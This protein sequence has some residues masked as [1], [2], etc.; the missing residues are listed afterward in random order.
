MNPNRNAAVA[1]ALSLTALLA[2]FG[3]VPPMP[4]PQEYHRFADQS[5]HFGIPHFFDSVSNLLFILAGVAGLRFLASGRAR[6]AFTDRREALA[7][8]WFFGASVLVGLGSGYYHLAPD[9]SRLFW[10]RAAIAMA[11][12]SWLA[13]IVGE[14]IDL[15]WGRRLLPL[16]VLAGVGSAVYWLWSE[17]AGRG[18]LRPYLFMQLVP[19]LGVPLL[20]WLY[21]PRY[22]GDRDILVV[23]ALYPAALAC[24]FLDKPIAGLLGFVSG[25]TLKH[26]LAAAAVWWV[27][28]GLRR[29]RPS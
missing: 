22:P 10:D 24:D 28:V 7:Y 9:D 17:S 19:M 5:L 13:A 15:A 21:R 26:V 12:M 4:Q 29:R 20:L 2:M 18:D 27:L 23:L 8:W 1:L 11:L 3:F 25:H 16:L 14:R 6:L